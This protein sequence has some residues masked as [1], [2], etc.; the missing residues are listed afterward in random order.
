MLV[1]VETVVTFTGE[2]GV[3]DATLTSQEC[4]GVALST[5]WCR[6]VTNYPLPPTAPPPSKSQARGFENKD[7]LALL[8]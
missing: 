6:S 7:D 2:Q 5:V 4:G 1:L 8:F 3:A